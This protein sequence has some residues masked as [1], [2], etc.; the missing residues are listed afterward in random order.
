MNVQSH[1]V[2]FDIQSHVGYSGYIHTQSIEDN[3]FV[4]TCH[5]GTVKGVKGGK[6]AQ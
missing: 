2:R 4:T 6:L 1:V 3:I 5:N